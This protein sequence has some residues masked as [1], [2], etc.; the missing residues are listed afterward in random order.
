MLDV[1]IASST[2]DCGTSSSFFLFWRLS[3]AGRGHIG[4]ENSKSVLARL[5]RGTRGQR[6]RLRRAGHKRTIPR[7]HGCT[8]TPQ[9]RRQNREQHGRIP[10]A[11]I[12]GD[13]GARVA[14]S[15][16]RECHFNFWRDWHAE[17]VAS[18]SDY[19]GQAAISQ[20]W[21][22]PDDRKETNVRNE[23]GTHLTFGDCGAD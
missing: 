23:S 3:G 10:V 8:T 14:N 5:A 2:D 17:R 1:G 4:E 6:K 15:L 22:R 19:G 9:Q 13:C 7:A 20:L 16:Q 21:M 11:S 18:G 12:L